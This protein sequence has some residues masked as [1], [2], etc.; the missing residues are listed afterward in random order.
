MGIEHFVVLAEHLINNK[1]ITHYILYEIIKE[2]VHE[3]QFTYFLLQIEQSDK[4]F[5]VENWLNEG[6]LQFCLMQHIPKNFKEQ[7]RKRHGMYGRGK[8]S[9]Y[10][11]EDELMK[12]IKLWEPLPNTKLETS[13]LKYL[14]INPEFDV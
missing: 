5:S 12:R 8:I 13:A 9:K 11:T 1:Q 10:T 7:K 2:K 6:E 14:F 3:N 4:S